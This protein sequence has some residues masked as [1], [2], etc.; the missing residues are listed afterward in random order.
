VGQVDVSDRLAGGSSLV[1][2]SDDLWAARV[3]GV[4][5][6]AAVVPPAKGTRRLVP[7]RL[8]PKRSRTSSS[9]SPSAARLEKPPNVLASHR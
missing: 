1:G 3:V 6:R 2:A 8:D 9:T 5:R 4:H 7:S